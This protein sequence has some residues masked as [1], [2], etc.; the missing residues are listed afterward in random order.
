M[1]YDERSYDLAR[2]FL[3]DEPTATEAD[4]DALAQHIQSEIE[5]W[6]NYELASRHAPPE[7]KLMPN[8]RG[9]QFADPADDLIF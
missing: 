3:A 6:L 2:H 7:D 4:A 5:S 8:D 9:E 1:S